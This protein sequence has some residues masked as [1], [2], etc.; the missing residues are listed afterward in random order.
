M[1]QEPVSNNALKNFVDVFLQAESSGAEP[2]S[3]VWGQVEELARRVIRQSE[4]VKR[5]ADVNPSDWLK[6]GQCMEFAAHSIVETDAKGVEVVHVLGFL[7][8]VADTMAGAIDKMTR[9]GEYG[10]L[11]AALNYK[12][13]Y[14]LAVHPIWIQHDT[15]VDAEPRDIQM[16][17]QALIAKT[18]TD[19]MWDHPESMACETICV[20]N[21]Y[22]PVVYTV[23]G[24]ME[25]EWS[26]EEV[27]EPCEFNQSGEDAIM[28]AFDQ[29]FTLHGEQDTRVQLYDVGLSHQVINEARTHRDLREIDTRLEMIKA[30]V[31]QRENSE[32]EA[33]LEIQLTWGS[34]VGDSI[35]AGEAPAIRFAVH[36]RNLE[37]DVMQRFVLGVHVNPENP[38]SW[39]ES[40]QHLLSMCFRVGWPQVQIKQVSGK[41]ALDYWASA[42]ASK[43]LM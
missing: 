28:A 40:L 15:L 7:P 35:E 11:S 25:P 4:R 34:G 43:V 6:A 31:T 16:L 1:A 27:Y 22:L 33:H 37:D 13:E 9:T 24:K 12:F 19:S 42:N 8:I 2:N 21:F 18:D 26:P 30:A 20:R 5:P 29:I 41:Q 3:Q 32:H 36:A 39:G 14:A 38:E 23:H 17:L 10:A